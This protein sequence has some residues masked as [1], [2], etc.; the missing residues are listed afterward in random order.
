MRIRKQPPPEGIDG[1]CWVW[2]GSAAGGYGQIMIDSAAV[3]VHRVMYERLKGPVEDGLQ[4]DHLCRVTRCCN[5]DHLEPVSAR[6]NI[7]RST[8]PAALNAV[9]TH[10]KNGHEFT[11][12]NTYARPDGSGR[13][14]RV[15]KVAAIQHRRD[16]HYL[17][18]GANTR[19]VYAKRFKERQNT[20]RP[21]PL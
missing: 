1:E 15:C 13:A 18:I 17:Q 10:C 4:L 2:M 14:C 11:P 8:G 12:E 19:G 5:P 7:L 16:M 6:I 20:N 9:K 3:K 21:I